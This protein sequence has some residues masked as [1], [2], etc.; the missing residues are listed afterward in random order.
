MFWHRCWQFGKFSHRGASNLKRARNALERKIEEIAK[1]GS[2][3]P[4]RPK[5]TLISERKLRP[6]WFNGKD[7]IPRGLTNPEISMFGNG[8]LAG[9]VFID[10]DEFKRQR[11]SGGIMDPLNYISGQV[12]FTA[13]GVLAAKTAE[14]NFNWARRRSSASRYRSRLY[15]SS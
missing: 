4:V 15:R 13:R 1:N 10:I 6:I 2:S 3:N 5:K 9:R 7:K 12:P 11:G 14:D 8:N